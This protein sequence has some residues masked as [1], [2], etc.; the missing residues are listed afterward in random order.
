MSCNFIFHFQLTIHYHLWDIKQ[1]FSWMLIIY[2]DD[3]W[4]PA[5]THPAGAVCVVAGDTHHRAPKKTVHSK[6]IAKHCASGMWPHLETSSHKCIHLNKQTHLC[7]DIAQ[8]QSELVLGQEA[9]FISKHKK[10]S[11]LYH[12]WSGQMGQP[13]TEQL[14]NGILIFRPHIGDYPDIPSKYMGVELAV[15]TS[16]EDRSRQQEKCC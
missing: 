1:Y 3:I 4:Q 15:H 2:T 5:S 10:V 7:R 9:V 6:V 16:P 13:I 11:R 14:E 12:S 8:Q